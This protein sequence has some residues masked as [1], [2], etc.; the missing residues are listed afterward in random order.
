M[1]DSE[2]PPEA[3]VPFE[4]LLRVSR[5]T[6]GAEPDGSPG[7][8]ALTAMRD[9]L[10]DDPMEADYHYMLGET[11][12]RL[13]RTSEGLKSLVEAS[14]LQPDNAGYQETLGC[15]YYQVGR[16]EEAVTA[17]TEALR[18]SPE[19][20]GA[21]EG[22]AVAMI[23]LGR[24][25]RALD[26]LHIAVRLDDRDGQVYNNLGVALWNLK[27]HGEALRAFKRAAGLNPESMPIARNLARALAASQQ[28]EEA[29]KALLVLLRKRPECAPAHADLGDLLFALGRDDE[30][31][32]A[33]ERA[34]SQ[35]ATVLTGRAATEHARAQITARRLKQEMQGEKTETP[36]VAPMA[37]FLSGLPIGRASLQGPKRVAALA[38]FALFILVLLRLA[39]A[40][41]PPYVRNFRFADKVSEIARAP[42]REDE[43]VRSLLM[44]VV[45][46]QGLGGRVS[47]DQCQ[48][49][50]SPDW[51]QIT[52]GYEVP[53]Q[54]LPGWRQALRFR[55]DVGAPFFLRDPPEHH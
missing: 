27:K 36:P 33:Y 39:V 52:C 45:E 18:L 20:H 51:R 22:L 29:V 9:A 4:L 28:A 54:I 15:T 50:T 55:V 14:R 49:T 46:Q 16:F 43:A 34:V 38:G 13:G 11:L 30:A 48:I 47:A 6:D 8:D 35:D 40:L 2:T 21:L 5:A 1:A 23:R 12:V 41:V 10:A 19:S 37:T 24:P 44:R 25:K 32:A 31:E 17:F 42:V 53:V 7:R 26:A 3:P